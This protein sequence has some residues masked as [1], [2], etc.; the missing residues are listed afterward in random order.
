MIFLAIALATWSSILPPPPAAVAAMCATGWPRRA[1]GP[2]SGCCSCSVRWRCCCCRCS[3]SSRAACG[4]WSR[5]RI[6]RSRPARA[7]WLR[8]IAFCCCWTRCSPPC[9]PRL[10]QPGGTLPA[11]MGGVSRPAGRQGHPRDRPGC[12][13]KRWRAGSRWRWRWSGLAGAVL[14]SRVFAVRLASLLT[15]P[16]RLVAK[17]RGRPLE[18]DEDGSSLVFKPAREKKAKEARPQPAAAEPR[19]ARPRSPTR[20]ARPSP[21]RSPAQSRQGD[22]FDEYELPPLDLL[23]DALPTTVPKAY[24]KL[25]LERNARLLGNRARRFQRQGDQRCAP[26]LSPD[27]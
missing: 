17:A 6:A 9:C 7:C 27:A 20:R 25:S 26:A 22:L 1:P 12:C 3:T 11:S 16:G 23:S 24:Y 4:G 18:D 15:L 14:A 10:H 8:P 2:A 21:R 19:A 13:R 5:K